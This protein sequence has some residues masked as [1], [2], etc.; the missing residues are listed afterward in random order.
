MR[1]SLKECNLVFGIGIVGMAQRAAAD[2][3]HV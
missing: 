2:V 1:K 3:L